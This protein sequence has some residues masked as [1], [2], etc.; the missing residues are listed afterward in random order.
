[1]ESYLFPKHDEG[2]AS[3]FA[4]RQYQIDA[5]HAASEALRSSQRC[6]LVLPCGCGKTEIGVRLIQQCIPQETGKALVVSPF[7]TL[8]GQTA[9]RLRVR[10]VP[11]GIEQGILRSAEQVTVAS[12]KSLISRDRYQNYLN[13]FSRGDLVIVDES[14]LNY[15]K[16]AL[17]ILTAFSELGCNIVGMTASP[18]RAKGDPITEFYGGVAYHYTLMQAIADGWL[19]PPKVWVT[20]ASALDLSRFDDGFGDFNAKQVA[21]AMAQEENVQTVTNLV[22]QHHEGEPSVVFCQGILQAEKVRQCLWRA[23]V[24]AAIVHSQMEEDER[25]MNLQ[26]F[27]NGTL[28]IVLNVGCLTIGWDCDIVRKLFMCKPTRSR[29]LYQQAIGRGTRPLAGTVDGWATAAQRRTA[30]YESAKR[31]F[32]V[33]DLVDCSRHNDLVTAIEALNDDLPPD[34]AKRVRLKR[35]GEEGV[36]LTKLGELIAAEQ[37]LLA[38]ENRAAAEQRAAL[39]ALTADNRRGFIADQRFGNYERDAFAQAEMPPAYRGWR[40]LFGQHKGTPLPQMDLGY[41]QWALRKNV[42]KGAFKDAVEREVRRRLS[43]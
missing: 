4:W 15:S 43:R 1:M 40:W 38:E 20:V 33:F 8:T 23:G 10:G 11:C 7:V 3:P 41:M 18:D 31:D 28:N 30:I 34:V 37:E 32:E 42:L 24:E 27:E 21:K 14:H 16:R 26:L 17:D 29:S 13:C 6:L 35:E 12:Y 19:V 25:R 5:V 2:V 36:P 9:N 39:E 22:L